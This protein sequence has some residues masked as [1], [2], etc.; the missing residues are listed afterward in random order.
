MSMRSTGSVW[1]RPAIII[2]TAMLIIFLGTAAQVLS[3]IDV[4]YTDLL[5]LVL[6]P[7]AYWYRRH[8]AYP[9][10]VVAALHIVAVYIIT[11]H[12]GIN[13]IVRAALLIIVPYLLGYFFEVVGRKTSGEHSAPA[14]DP[15]TRKLVAKL[16]SR[17]SETRYQAVE[18]L[19]DRRD[20]AV[21]QSL[22]PLLDDPESGVRW[23]TAEALGKLGPPAVGP[24][25]D[26][27][28][29]GDV[30]VRWMAAV[31][32][33]DIA[34]PA[35]VPALLETL[36]DVDAYV[37]SRAALALA[38][39]GEPAETALITSLST[40]NERVRW[41]ATLA[42]G[43]IGGE[44]ATSA[45]IDALHD[46]DEDIRRQTAN[47]LEDMGEAA[48]PTL[49]AMLRISDPSIRDEIIG[50]LT[51]IGK[52]ATPSLVAALRTSKDPCIR[53]GAALALGGISDPV[54]ADALNEALGDGEEGVRLAAGEA[55]GD[56]RRHNLSEGTPELHD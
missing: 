27:L 51:Q 39:I 42:L 7:A 23:K 28:R 40:G 47:A 54:T 20:P 46:P 26:G 55:L 4:A 36:N 37:R 45:L 18:C 24:L 12:V 38:A 10:M 13:T 19:G 49:I 8:A 31:A 5:Y 6:V 21:V 17:N 11:G 29:S 15:D 1:S 16:S 53:A 48:I 44:V 30:D 33:G 35:A 34:D 50:A 52:P 2:L 9:G 43:R 41:G 22:A 25:I 56:I 32:L 3:G 14:C